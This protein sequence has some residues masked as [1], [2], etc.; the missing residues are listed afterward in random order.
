VF[1]GIPF[2]KRL[3]ETNWK[4]KRQQAKQ[5]MKKSLLSLALFSIVGVSFSQTI[6]D[7]KVSFGYTQLPYFKINDAFTSYDIKVVHG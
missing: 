1:F 5:V 4:P 3:D 6:N 2:E 7:N